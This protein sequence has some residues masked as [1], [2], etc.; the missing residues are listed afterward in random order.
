MSK[1]DEYV[2]IDVNLV[3][4]YL[5]QNR[6]I[7]SI[8]EELCIS[9]DM[10]YSWCRRMRLAG[11]IEGRGQGVRPVNDK[12]SLRRQE[13]EKQFIKMRKE[14]RTLDEIATT[15]GISLVGAKKISSSL[16]ERGLIEKLSQ[17]DVV[18]RDQE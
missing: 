18:K 9:A 8:A 7:P 10:L 11:E 2:E 16:I 12:R 3:K 4:K 15:L 1:K 13:R 6:S 5:R 14:N 17:S